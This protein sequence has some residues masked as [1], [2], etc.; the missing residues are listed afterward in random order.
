MKRIF[1]VAI[2]TAAC[3]SAN[4]GI[5]FSDNFESEVPDN[6]ELIGSDTNFNGFDNWL[7]SQGTV[8]LVL[9][10]DW[11]KICADGAGY[12]VD[13]DGS[14][15]NA[16]KMT[17]TTFG[18]LAG[19]YNFSFELSGN[20]RLD[21][22]DTVMVN[23]DGFISDTITLNKNDPWQTFSYNFNVAADTTSF[24]SFNHSGG[25]NAGLLL[26]N[27]LVESTIQVP[28]PTSLALLGMGLAGLIAARRRKQTI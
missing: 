14:S 6:I 1:S 8:D 17:S 4:A 24:I 25:D 21:T 28:E 2:L 7:V 22:T 3:A 13:L 15:Y 27:V 11:N 12:C 23:L 16:G 19:D 10:G 18:L 20:Q 9:H 26:D 5:I